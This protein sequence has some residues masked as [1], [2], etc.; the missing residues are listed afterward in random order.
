MALVVNEE[1]NRELTAGVVEALGGQAGRKGIALQLQADG[2]LWIK[3]GIGVDKD[4]GVVVFGWE[5]VTIDAA[6]F[7]G[8]PGD[9]LEVNLRVRWT[10]GGISPTS[11]DDQTANLRY[12]EFV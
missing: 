10:P 4:V 5:L 9:F 3:T 12:V 11:A 2:E 6:A 1:S 7:G 8:A